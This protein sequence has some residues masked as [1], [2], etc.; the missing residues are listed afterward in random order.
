MIWGI[1][2]LRKHHQGQR[3]LVN[4]EVAKK[5]KYISSSIHQNRITELSKSI[6]ST[7]EIIQL[8]LKQKEQYIN[9]NKFQQAA[10]VNST[11]LKKTTEKQK[12][13]R[14]LKSLQQVENRSHHNS[15]QKK[16]HGRAVAAIQIAVQKMVK[17]V[18]LTH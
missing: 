7:G 13:E 12:L 3:T 8:L 16:Y 2:M 4:A 17:A 6:K 11:I 18:V 15:R 14:E 5:R 10:D 9:I 1:N